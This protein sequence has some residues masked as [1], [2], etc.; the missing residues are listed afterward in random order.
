MPTATP[1]TENVARGGWGTVEFAVLES[2]E[3]PA[4]TF[5]EETMTKEERMAFAV[6]FQQMADYGIV[7]K[8]KFS[9]Y[10]SMST[11]R[12]VRLQIRFPCFRDGQKWILTQG[13]YKPG[14]K[15]KKGQWPKSEIKRFETTK[16]QYEDRKK[17]R[18]EN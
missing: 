16:K 7:P 10:G 11:F 15:K 3:V 17:S 18:K 5:Y 1:L 6:V 8:K 14:A 2:G 4:K 13:F 12:D 9:S